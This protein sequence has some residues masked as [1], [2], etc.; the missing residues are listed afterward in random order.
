MDLVVQCI[1]TKFGP[2]RLGRTVELGQIW[3]KWTWACSGS[4]LNLGQVDLGVQWIWST[5]GP[6][7]ELGDHKLIVG[8]VGQA[9]VGGDGQ[10]QVTR[11]QVDLGQSVLRRVQS[12]R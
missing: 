3:A 2:N 11:N 12:L 8:R 9:V 10:P 7:V 5:F 1:W 4:G 6:K